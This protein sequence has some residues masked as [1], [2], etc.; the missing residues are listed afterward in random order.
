MIDI[1]GITANS[2]DTLFRIL[3]QLVTPGELLEL[4]KVYDP[5]TGGYTDSKVTHSIS[6]I[7][8][9]DYESSQIDNDVIRKFDQQ[10]VFRTSEILFDLT[11]E[12]KLVIDGAE[13]DIVNFERDPSET[14]YFLQI[15]RP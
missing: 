1:R 5:A 15:R 11:T 13:W 7:I 2:V 12:M 3:Q 6:E 9:Y 4:A 14:V 10:A 8:R